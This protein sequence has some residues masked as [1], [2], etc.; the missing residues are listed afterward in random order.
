MDLL[1]L[2]YFQCV[3]RNEHMTKAA[4]ELN[5]AQPALSKSISLLEQNLGVQLFDRKGKK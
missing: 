1:Q 5:L 2:K 4:K 3:A